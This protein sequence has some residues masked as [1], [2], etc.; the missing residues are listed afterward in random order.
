MRTTTAL[1]L[2]LAAATLAAADPG[3]GDLTIVAEGF[4]SEKGTVLIQLANSA[5][6]YGDDAG[7][8]RHAEV[9]AAG[10][11]ATAVFEGV[12]FGDYAVKILHDEN[13]N[14]K[15]DMGWRGPTERYGFSND[16]RGLIGPPSYDAAKFTLAAKAHRIEI[17]VK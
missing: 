6:D 12:P 15:I 4:E 3:M 17:Q 5:E 14:K 13:D 9:K 11:Q 10:G 16:A 1:A 8:F 7:A 2:L